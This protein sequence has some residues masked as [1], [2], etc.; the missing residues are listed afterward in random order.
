MGMTFDALKGLLD[1]ERLNYF[2]HP[3]AP[4]AMFGLNGVSGPLRITVSLQM[5]GDFL[6]FASMDYAKCPPDSPHLA[7]VLAVLSELNLG[8]RWV[9]WCRDPRSGE[10]LVN[11]DFWVM[12]NPPSSTQFRRMLQN[13]IPTMDEK[14]P[15]ILAVIATGRDP[16]DAAAPPAGPPSVDTL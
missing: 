14:R 15:R 12:D 3:K 9:K 5:D 4:A 7:A 13:I 1:G 10:I 6:Q 2:I 16:G 8:L 11:G